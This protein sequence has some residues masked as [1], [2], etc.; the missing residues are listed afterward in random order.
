LVRI[1]KETP[2]PERLRILHLE[3]NARDGE[4]VQACLESEGFHFERIL[5][6][7]RQEF[8]TALE[9]SPFDLILSDYT[10]PSYDGTAALELARRKHPHTPFIFV[11]GTIGE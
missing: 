3:D 4:L 11:S 1:V 8:E 10:L 6:R 2:P 7:S 5:A 9:Q